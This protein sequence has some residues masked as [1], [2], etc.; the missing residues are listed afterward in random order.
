MARANNGGWD[1]VKVGGTYQYKEETFPMSSFIA[2]VKILEDNSTE[3][4]YEFKLQVI[5]SNE[6]PPTADGVFEISNIKKSDGYYSG[7]PQFYPTPEY[8]CHYQWVLGGGK[9][10]YSPQRLE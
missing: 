2:M 4:A 5:E 3:D 7:M 6:T 8:S 9:S 10:V 1:F